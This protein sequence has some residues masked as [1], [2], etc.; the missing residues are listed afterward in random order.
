M[1]LQADIPLMEYAISGK[2]EPLV[3]VPGG[4]TGWRSWIPH[5]EAL[6]ASR[7]V[8][9]LQL[10]NVQFGLSGAPLPPTYSVDYEV[11]A[12]GNTLDDLAIE[13][14]DVAGWSYGTIIALSYALHHPQRVQSLTLIEP[15][16]YWVL[17]SRGP[18]SKEVLDEQS[19]LQTLATDDLSEVQL[20]EFMHVF[21]LVPEDVD[22]R[23][24][25]QWP[26]LFNHRQSLRIGDIEFR[27]EDSLEL[28]R[29]YEKPVLLV[30]GEGSNPSTHAIADVLAEEFPKAR[31]VTLPGGHA[32][33]IES[34]QPFLE[35]FTRFLSERN[36]AQ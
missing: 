27:H 28:V 10:H 12:L 15:S 31:V 9:R 2:G 32:P 5:A 18:L 4:F 26:V 20:V 11:A 34:M 17:R 3:L 14:A 22:P 35:L 23:T 21:R 29:S 24:L 7:R 33:H 8:I 19:Y 16:A 1:S 36:R 25:P 30:K 6:T 13:Q